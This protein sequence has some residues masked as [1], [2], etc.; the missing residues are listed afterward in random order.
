MC[1]LQIQALRNELE[2]LEFPALLARAEREGVESVDGDA[3]MLDQTNHASLVNRIVRLHDGLS[4]AEAARFAE[5]IL[6]SGEATPG[7]MATRSSLT[8]RL[9]GV[10][11]SSSNSSGGLGGSYHA[12]LWAS[13]ELREKYR[14]VLTL[15]ASGA[16]TDEVAALFV[17][18]FNLVTTNDDGSA[19]V[20]AVLGFS[21]SAEVEARPPTPSAAGA[22][23]GKLLPGT[24]ES[25]E[26]DGGGGGGGG[27]SDYRYDAGDSDAAK[28]V[29]RSPGEFV[30]GFREARYGMQPIVCTEFQ[31]AARSRPTSKFERR[32]I[33]E[34]A[35]ELG[36]D[37]EVTGIG[38][39]RGNRAHVGRHV[40]VG[41]YTELP[42]SA[43]LI[44]KRLLVLRESGVLCD[45]ELDLH[46]QDDGS[47]E[48]EDDEGND[49]DK[50]NPGGQPAQEPRR[51]AAAA[52]PVAAAAAAP[53][54]AAAA[55]GG[56]GGGEE[57]RLLR[58]GASLRVFEGPYEA[59]R[60]RGRVRTKYGWCYLRDGDMQPLVEL[61]MLPKH[62]QDSD[63]EQKEGDGYDAEALLPTS[64]AGTAATSI[65]NVPATDVAEILPLLDDQHAD[66][67]A[68]A[69]G[70]SSSNGT[71]DEAA[72]PPPP[73]L[74]YQH[75]RGWVIP[76]ERNRLRLKVRADIGRTVVSHV[77]T[78]LLKLK[79]ALDAQSAK[80]LQEQ[81][82][83]EGLGGPLLQAAL[84]Y[85]E[86]RLI[87][88]HID[89]GAVSAAAEGVAIGPPS[90]APT[91]ARDNGEGKDKGEDDDEAVAARHALYEER[92][93]KVA[94]IY[95]EGSKDDPGNKII[96]DLAEGV[97][98]NPRPSK[99]KHSASA[100]ASASGGG[101]GGNLKPN[102][103]VG[104]ALEPAVVETASLSEQH[105]REIDRLCPVLISTTT[106]GNQ[107]M[108]QQVEVKTCT[109]LEQVIVAKLLE[110]ESIWQVNSAT[111][112]ALE[113]TQ[114]QLP[115]AHSGA[116]SVGSSSSSSFKYTTTMGIDETGDL[117]RTQ[118]NSQVQAASLQV[119]FRVQSLGTG[120]EKT[121]LKN[122]W[123]NLKFAHSSLDEAAQ[124]LAQKR[125]EAQKKEREAMKL[126][127]DFDAKLEQVLSVLSNTN[128]SRTHTKE[129]SRSDRGK[130]QVVRIE[131]VGC[132]ILMV[133][134]TIGRV[135]QLLRDLERECVEGNGLGWLGS[136]Y[137]VVTVLDVCVA[138]PTPEPFVDDTA[139]CSCVSWIY[140]TDRLPIEEIYANI[141]GGSELTADFMWGLACAGVIAA[142]RKQSSNHHRIIIII[143]SF[144]RRQFLSRENRSFVQPGLSRNTHTY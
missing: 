63:P 31:V 100:S 42:V 30:G 119:L 124:Q 107:T 25:D 33:I 113:E 97:K 2:R 118:S 65:V 79:E 126:A 24:G 52:A 138:K 95:H 39:G 26:D 8:G 18:E 51:A 116:S 58:H 105:D 140:P 103:A 10:A 28:A 22:A 17:K 64:S 135:D 50:N 46:S 68:A 117:V 144:L 70:A 96:E 45:D 67:A 89:I 11:A 81:V 125:L 87:G 53:P 19:G 29:A 88:S 75:F 128:M 99:P 77:K 7:V 21:T 143:A 5:Q 123:V 93:A 37:H 108:Q 16:P 71:E 20:A 102:K 106:G 14:R 38:T 120:K 47:S 36:L 114:S 94:K 98:L 85:R 136:R 86:Q 134:C 83:R 92:L 137:G 90:S 80:D 1:A 40:V 34:V 35:H 115:S 122:A 54:A 111:R 101:G 76:D 130:E 141:N 104:F 62:H 132:T 127:T 131:A 32:M 6:G 49:E 84:E 91:T 4:E 15:F 129:D 109:E 3:D 44:G 82:E 56:A 27:G 23:K 60:P 72:A 9:S 12:D 61:Q 13:V 69:A 55:A 133:N 78:E 112:S 66:S 139:K 110:H 121:E 41:R 43:H 59:E 57:W 73:L 142:V 74:T 48:D